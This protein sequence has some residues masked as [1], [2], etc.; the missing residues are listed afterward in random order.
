MWSPAVARTAVT[1]DDVIEKPVPTKKV[2]AV[3][4]SEAK[5][6]HVEGD[7]ELSVKIGADGLVKDATIKKS[8]PPLD[9][10]ALAAIRQWEFR[11]G[12]VNG[13]AVE[14]MTTITFEFRL[15]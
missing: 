8:V 6:K 5:A 13:Q 10:A 9:E 3:Y 15:K 1:P 2:E 12:R 7:V 14:V 11:A 4:P